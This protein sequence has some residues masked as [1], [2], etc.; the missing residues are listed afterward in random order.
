MEAAP[1]ESA[2]DEPLL[3]RVH[4]AVL[5][6]LACAALT[7][8]SLGTQSE[9]AATEPPLYSLAAV[10]LAALAIL[11]RGARVGFAPRLP[12]ARRRAV[13]SLLCAGTLGMLGLAV[14]TVEEQQQT[15]L[16]YALAGAL[17][18]L[19]PPARELDAAEPEP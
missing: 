12:R 10:G 19:R 13:I 7:I 16:L 3:R 6:V 8:A 18:A 15:G 9:E 17:L 5:A 1:P 4:I 2:G 14:G 11:S